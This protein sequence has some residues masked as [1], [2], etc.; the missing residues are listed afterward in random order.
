MNLFLLFFV[1]LFVVVGDDG[2]F[3]V[4]RDLSGKDASEIGLL[5]FSFNKI[6]VRLCLG[7]FDIC[8]IIY[9]LDLVC[10]S[11]GGDD[12]EDEVKM[13]TGGSVSS[14]LSEGLTSNEPYMG[15]AEH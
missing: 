14:A 8:S 13:S 5:F 11:F 4:G 10:L 12:G 3:V 9:W 6:G 1:G 7:V 15:R 2:K